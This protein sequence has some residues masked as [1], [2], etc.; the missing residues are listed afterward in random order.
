MVLQMK[1]KIDKYFEKKGIKTVYNCLGANERLIRSHL[2]NFNSTVDRFKNHHSNFNKLQIYT[3]MYKM[4][5]RHKMTGFENFKTQDNF[6]R[7]EIT[8]FII[9]AQHSPLFAIDNN[10]NHILYDYKTELKNFVKTIDNPLLYLSGGLD[11]ELVAYAMLDAG[12]NFKTVIFQWIKNGNIENISEVSHAYAFCKQ[13]NINPIIKSVEVEKLWKTQYFKN[14]AIDLQILSTQLVT[15]SHMI[16]LMSQEEPN[17]THIFGGEV[18]FKTNYYT[19]NGERANL[20]WLDKLTPAYNGDTFFAQYV[21]A[22]SGASIG[23]YYNDDG[24]WLI[25]GFGGDPVQILAV[26]SVNGAPSF[27]TWTDT[28]AT[29][30]EARV[31]Y[32]NLIDSNL[33]YNVYPNYAPYPWQTIGGGYGNPYEICSL[34]VFAPPAFTTNYA[35]VYFDIEVRVVGE[36]TPV[37]AS[38]L[39]L[40]VESYAVF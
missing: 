23:L 15:H 18:K 20:V 32:W 40:E 5:E 34:T 30:Y 37:Q 24:S 36:T 11:S 19:D 13:H 17:V 39:T 10:D 16:N 29:V 38:N 6:F 3:K 4:N 2:S 1:T 35:T 14:L 28:P 8:P 21:G 25:E 31:L 33:T 27:G 7:R 22:S 9:E 26:N 12:V